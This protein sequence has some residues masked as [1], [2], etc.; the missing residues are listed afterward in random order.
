VLAFEF[1]DEVV[2]KTVVKVLTTEMG[3]TGSGLDFEDA[4]LNGQQGHIESTT[5]KIED[6]DVARSKSATVRGV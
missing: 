6:E 5:S 1:V 3:V 2:D 4:L